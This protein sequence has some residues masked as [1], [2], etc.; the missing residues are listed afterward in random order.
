M[1][2][3]ILLVLI[4]LVA[5]M[6]MTSCLGRKKIDAGYDGIRVNKYGDE[7]GVDKISEVTGVVWYNKIKYDI[8]EVPTFMLDYELP[9]MKFT[10]KDMM[11]VTLSA[12]IQLQNPA[13]HT[14]KL[15]VEYRRYFKRGDVDLNPIVRKFG[16]QAFSDA[17]GHFSAE[18][19]IT[20][21]TEFRML[22]DSLAKRE[23]EDLGFEVG[24]LFLVGDPQL[25]P[26]IVQAV[27]DKIKA[28]QVADMKEQELAQTQADVAKQIEQARGDSI[29]IVM[30]AKAN[31]LAYELKK[32][33]LNNELLQQQ[34]I[35]K[36]NGVL[37]VYGEVP[38]LFK[39]V[40]GK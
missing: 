31:A 22:A 29:Q 40:T 27:N 5:G 4:I 39:G 17:A 12:S 32:K 28:K 33:E 13:G 36:W 20:R 26:S 37:P 21:K 23:L 2:S 16:R 38:S 10:T 1:K 6:S 15:F 24:E 8:Y 14:P 30:V 25:P 19:L 3:R 9:D 34:F 18:E 7:K 11:E 35:E